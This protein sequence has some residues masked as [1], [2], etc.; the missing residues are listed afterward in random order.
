MQAL[1][2]LQ[3]RVPAPRSQPTQ[4]E[5]RI[6]GEG[7]GK[8]AKLNCSFTSLSSSHNRKTHLCLG[9][10]SPDTKSQNSDLITL[11]S[12]FAVYKQLWPTL[13]YLILTTII[14]R[15]YSIASG[16]HRVE[17]FQIQD[18]FHYVALDPGRWKASS[19]QHHLCLCLAIWDQAGRE[20]SI[21]SPEYRNLIQYKWIFLLQLFYIQ[22]FLRIYSQKI[23]SLLNAQ[24]YI[25]LLI[26]TQ[27]MNISFRQADWKG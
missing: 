3:Q 21:I 2:P 4:K 6:K 24:L 1:Q 18:L 10:Q 16:Q 5:H 17:Q 13:S 22:D 27:K 11:I 14:Y 26:L 9:F 19:R 8:R 20:K 15:W 25:S 12:S 23:S 7:D